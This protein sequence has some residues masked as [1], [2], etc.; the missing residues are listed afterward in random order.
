M[1]LKQIDNVPHKMLP[2]VLLGDQAIWGKRNA[3]T[4]VLGWLAGERDTLPRQIYTLIEPGRIPEKIRP[5]MAASLKAFGAIPLIDDPRHEALKAHYAMLVAHPTGSANALLGAFGESNSDIVS[6]WIV[7]K[8]DAEPLAAHLRHAAFACDANRTRYLTRWYDPLIIPS[9]FRLGDPK[10][11][12]WLLGPVNSYWYPVAAPRQETWR[13]VEGMGESVAPPPVPLVIG[14]ELWEATVS[15]PLPYQLLN[16]A[17]N[18]TPS[19]F[20][21]HCDGVRLAKIEDMLDAA[22][23]QGLKQPED[24][25]VY[26]LSLLEAPGRAGEARWQA[27]LQQAAAGR[28]PLK[29]YF[30]A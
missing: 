25:T 24:L 10:W 7:S 1:K 30:S 29:A 21:S 26:V 2:D 8:L 12:R 5:K 28:A 15:D 13:R 17:N 22:K 14:E 11:V 18:Q 19:A 6:A 16:I 23:R 20:E 3:L 9:L 27:A 4:R